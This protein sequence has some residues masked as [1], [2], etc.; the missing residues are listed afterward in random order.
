[1]FRGIAIPS[2]LDLLDI[3]PIA[4]GRGQLAPTG[5]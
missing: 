3:A 2:W 4:P 1:M 5:A